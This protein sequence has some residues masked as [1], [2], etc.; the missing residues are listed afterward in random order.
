MVEPFDQRQID[1][2]QGHVIHV[3]QSGNPDG[4]PVITLYRRPLEA[5]AGGTG[6]P[7]DAALLA[8]LVYATLVEQWAALTGVN[9]ES[10]DPEHTD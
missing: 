1:V 6:A 4:V 5:R 8:E 2:G 10:V 3:E 9:P 7:P